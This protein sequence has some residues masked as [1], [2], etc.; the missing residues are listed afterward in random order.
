MNISKIR[1]YGS[2][3]IGV[4]VFAND[5][6]AI[7][8]PDLDKKVLNDISETL[9]VEI[10]ETKVAKTVL[11]GVMITGNNYGILLPRTVTEDEYSYLKKVLSKHGLEV[12]VTR[13]KYTALGN[14]M[15]VNNKAAV[16]NEEFEREELISIKEVLNVNIHTRNVMNL[17]IPG[18]LAV[19]TDRGGVIHPDVPD[20]EVKV[21]MNLF[22]VYIEKATVNSGIPF[23][24]SGIVTNNK[25]ILVGEITTGP[26]ILRVRRGLGGW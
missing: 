4:F 3:H 21:L 17:T 10:V 8:P 23:V 20:D 11:N 25:G 7:V 18:G 5:K 13:S 24:K 14:V 12:Y 6:A 9:N 19:V 16:V 2:P 15:L 22:G 26:E 1:V